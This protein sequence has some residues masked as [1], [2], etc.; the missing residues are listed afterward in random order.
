VWGL[1]WQ[2]VDFRQGFITVRRSYDG[3]TKNGKVRRVP[4]LAKAREA[5]ES[6]RGISGRW[7]LVFP[8]KRGEMRAHGYDAQLRTNLRRA[9]IGRRVR[10]HDLRHSCAS[11]L[12]MGSWGRVWSLLEVKELLGHSTVT[13]T[14]RYSHLSFGGILRAAK[15]TIM[16]VP[17]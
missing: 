3:P 8:S 1:Q 14:E 17:E 2:D 13:V 15:E 7:K 12:V 4:L 16:D 9:G 10:F 6:Q 5:L 11:H